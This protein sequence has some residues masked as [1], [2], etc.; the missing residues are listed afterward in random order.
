MVSNHDKDGDDNSI[1]D[2]EAWPE[3]EPD[4]D[5]IVEKDGIKVAA[6]GIDADGE[7]R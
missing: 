5:G 6:T 3:P 2:G 7:R 1:G 4:E